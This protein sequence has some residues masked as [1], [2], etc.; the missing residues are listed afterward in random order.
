M[1]S[2]VALH[3]SKEFQNSCYEMTKRNLAY[4]QM[5]LGGWTLEKHFYAAHEIMQGPAKIIYITAL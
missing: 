4:L 1:A 2:K 3:I 5:K